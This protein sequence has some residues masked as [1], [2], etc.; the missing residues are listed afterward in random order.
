MIE[1]DAALASTK[2]NKQPGPDL[3]IMELFSWMN[4]DN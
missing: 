2:A 1:V 4:P 3:I